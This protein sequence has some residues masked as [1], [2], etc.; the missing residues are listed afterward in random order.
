M[1]HD[2]DSDIVFLRV[3]YAGS[4]CYCSVVCLFVLFFFSH[5]LHIYA[6]NIFFVHFIL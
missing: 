2:N 1:Q 4:S 5:P 6:I 3:D